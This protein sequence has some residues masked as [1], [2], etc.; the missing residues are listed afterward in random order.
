MTQWLHLGEQRFERF[1]F[2]D[3]DLDQ[4]DRLEDECGLSLDAIADLIAEAAEDDQRYFSTRQR[5]TAIKALVWTART[6]A[7]EELPIADAV[8]GVAVNTIWIEDDEPAPEPEE[9]APDPTA[10]ASAPAAD[11]EPEAA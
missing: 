5:R 2:D 4:L 7:G 1:G 10:A 3:L 8:R 9:V 11:P 6:L